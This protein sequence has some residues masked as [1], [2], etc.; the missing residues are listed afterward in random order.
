MFGW[1][2][3]RTHPAD[4][5]VHPHDRQELRGRPAGELV[6][7]GEHQPQHRQPGA[8]GDQRLE[9]LDEE[10]GPGLELVHG[11]DA[12]EDRRQRQGTPQ[13]AHQFPTAE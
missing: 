1:M 10:V 7:V 4:Q 11:A 13:P 6:G 12:Q 5:H 2:A 8:D 9:E 3:A